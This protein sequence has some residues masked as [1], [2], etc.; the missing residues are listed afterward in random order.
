MEKTSSPL[1][2]RDGRREDRTTRIGQP[3][4]LPRRKDSSE[5]AT[6]LSLMMTIRVTL[7]KLLPMVEDIV[8]CLL[9]RSWGWSFLVEILYV[10]GFGNCWVQRSCQFL[11]S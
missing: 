2:S 8:S 10:D 5:K 7:S 9:G 4:V 3:G 1:E 6:P 11:S